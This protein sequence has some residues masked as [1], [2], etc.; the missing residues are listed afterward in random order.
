[1]T[2]RDGDD[3][4]GRYRY[5]PWTGGADPLAVHRV[6]QREDGRL[7]DAGASG[8]YLFHPFRRDLLAAAVDDVL[9]PAR[10]GQVSTGVDGAEIACAQP[11]F[12]EGAAA[13]RPVAEVAA[14]DG[15]TGDPDL[16]VDDPRRRRGG[17]ADA[18][19]A[20]IGGV[21]ERAAADV[22]GRLGHAVGGEHR[23]PEL[24]LQ[25][26]CGLGCQRCAAAAHET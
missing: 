7:R 23:H 4:H 14:G 13:E 3:V 26:G 22:V 5:S 8:E 6:R 11:S 12:D 24:R 1:M 19:A 18:A 25:T 2:L 9:D 15:R 20:H 16:A 21:A 10:D 17:C